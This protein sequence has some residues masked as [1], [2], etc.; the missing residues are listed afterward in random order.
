M[1]R[2]CGLLLQWCSIFRR[3]SHVVNVDKCNPTWTSF[4]FNNKGNNLRHP[5]WTFH[6]W[7]TKRR[8]HA[9]ISDTRGCNSTPQV[10]TVC[11]AIIQQSETNLCYNRHT[12]SSLS[13]SVT[14]HCNRFNDSQGII[15]CVSRVSQ[16]LLHN[17]D[18]SITATEIWMGNYLVYTYLA[19]DAISLH[20]LSSFAYKDKLRQ[21]YVTS[22][23]HYVFFLLPDLSILWCPC[24]RVLRQY[25]S[26]T[27]ENSIRTFQC[28]L[29]LLF[30]PSNTTT[31]QLTCI[32]SDKLFCDCL[33]MFITTIKFNWWKCVRTGRKYHYFIRM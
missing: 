25:A 17:L 6:C 11:V 1:R 28:H 15:L 31:S 10:T 13:F 8:N 4:C 33:V 12:T 16:H 23:K 19:E 18:S 3:M 20:E 7:T 24:R 32:M 2:G 14:R 9:R 5:C 22:V 27:K 21:K 26:H 29:L 30:L